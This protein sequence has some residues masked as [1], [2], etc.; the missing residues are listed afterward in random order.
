MDTCLVSVVSTPWLKQERC[1]RFVFAYFR[2][3]KSTRREVV[4]HYFG[5]HTILRLSL[6]VSEVERGV[7]KQITVL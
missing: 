7:T 5:G 6:T 2:M 4:S 1:V 3:K